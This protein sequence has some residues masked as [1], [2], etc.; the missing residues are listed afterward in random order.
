MEQRIQLLEDK[1]EDLDKNLEALYKVIYKGNGHPSLIS[2]VQKLDSKLHA[3]QTEMVNKFQF[4]D[5]ETSL[6]FETLHSKIDTKFSHIE[7]L[8]TTVTESKKIA[9]AGVWQMRAALMGSA[10]AVIIAPIT[11]IFN[12]LR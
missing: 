10:T 7:H 1:I 12:Y 9:V 6:R 8:L 2:Q 5:K 4:M 3:L 11:I